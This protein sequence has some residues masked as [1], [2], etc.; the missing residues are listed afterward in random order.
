MRKALLALSAFAGVL[1]ALFLC[2][3]VKAEAHDDHCICGGTTACIPMAQKYG[4]E[5]DA[6]MGRTEVHWQEAANIAQLLGY[7][8]TARTNGDS[9]VYIYLADSNEPFAMGSSSIL[10]GNAHGLHVHICLNGRT[11]TKTSDR[12]MTAYRSGGQSNMKLSLCDCSAGKTGRVDRTGTAISVDGAIVTLDANARLYLYSVTLTGGKAKNGGNVNVGPGEMYMYGATVD[13]GEATN[14][15]GNIYV[16]N[17]KLYSYGGSVTGGSASMNGGSIRVMA[18]KAF[19]YESTISDGVAGTSGTGIGGNLCIG[20]TGTGNKAEVVIDGGKV[21]GGA[22]HVATKNGHSITIC[23]AKLTLSGDLIFANACAENFPIY[24]TR[25]DSELYIKDDVVMYKT[26][27]NACLVQAN[28]SGANTYIS[29]GTFNGLISGNSGNIYVSGGNFSSISHS[30]VDSKGKLEITGGNFAGI[31]T[32]A[33]VSLPNSDWKVNDS[34]WIPLTRTATFKTADGTTGSFTT[35]YSVTTCQQLTE[36]NMSLGENIALGLFANVDLNEALYKDGDKVGKLVVT[37]DDKTQEAALTELMDVENAAKPTKKFVYKGVTPELMGDTITATL[38]ASDGT[39]VLDTKTYTIKEY[40]LSLKTESPAE[41]SLEEKMNALVNDLL[42]YGGRAQIKF[43]HNTDNLVSEGAVSSDRAPES[44]VERSVWT[45]TEVTI[46]NY[47]DASVVPGYFNAAT[48]IH[49]NVNWIRV[50]YRD[51]AKDDG[52]TFKIQKGNAEAVD[53]TLNQGYLC[54]EGLNP[55]EYDTKIT[56]YAYRGEELISKV[57]YSINAYCVKR[58]G[59]DG[60]V[61]SDALYN[62]GKSVAEYAAA[63]AAQAE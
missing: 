62:Y 2:G 55:T 14:E 40:L 34:A 35:N 61:F 13:G 8:N 39:T 26:G 31:P 24:G 51:N 6:N 23:N 47:Q 38:Y 10:D 59:A 36:R 18:G 3:N 30:Y 20:L 50:Q 17:G 7:V 57:E 45:K 27:G 46:E 9:D 48:V 25:A 43:N 16:N 21:L 29:G 37:L 54:T 42:V 44:G 53:A 28:V 58:H 52:T 49:E 63:V 5:G 33:A 60:A 19:F 12:V 41:G 11:L 4:H 32:G 15:G 22:N 1:L 56:F